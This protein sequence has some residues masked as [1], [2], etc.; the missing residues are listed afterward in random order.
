M[1]IFL[2]LLLLFICFETHQQLAVKETVQEPIEKFEPIPIQNEQ[3]FQS[4][5]SNKKEELKFHTQHLTTRPS[6]PQEDSVQKINDTAII[7]SKK[8]KSMMTRDWIYFWILL[9]M[10]VRVG[11]PGIPDF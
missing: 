11:W 6:A 9:Y 7:I 8:L 1:Q 4:S 5:S 3:I 10:C 2:L